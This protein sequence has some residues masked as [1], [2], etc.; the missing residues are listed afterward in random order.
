[1]TSLDH[2][3]VV[4]L[5]D[6]FPPGNVSSIVRAVQIFPSLSLE[7]RAKIDDLAWLLRQ[8][9]ASNRLS[10]TM[11]ELICLADCYSQDR[12]GSYKLTLPADADRAFWV[13]HFVELSIDSTL[14]IL[15]TFGSLAASDQSMLLAFAQ[16]SDQNAPL[17]DPI[18]IFLALHGA[19]LRVGDDEYR[20]P[21][22]SPYLALH[23]DDGYE[24]A[25]YAVSLL[26]VSIL[27]IHEVAEDIL[28]HLAALVPDS[29]KP[30]QLD[31]ARQRVYWPGVLYRGADDTTRN[32]LIRALQNG[33]DPSRI[34]VALAWIGDKVIESLFA[35]W[36]QATPAW[37]E[38]RRVRME[39]YALTAGWHLTKGAERRDLGHSTSYGL[40]SPGDAYRSD[41]AVDVVIPREDYCRWCDRRLVTLL[42]LNLSDSRLAFLGLGSGRL[43]I[44]MC[45][46]CSLY[47]VVF[48]EVDL[49]GES[50]WS[51]LNVQPDIIDFDYEPPPLPSHALVL[52]PHNPTPVVAELLD[53][54]QIGGYPGWVQNADY[55][56][57]PKCQLPMPFVGQV[58]VADI[59]R[60][61]EGI[62]YAFLCPGCLVAATNYQQT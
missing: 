20:H 5:L 11:L 6:L 51:E 22:V 26:S 33:D 10:S 47:S 29:L 4:H 23:P 45:E 12:D 31:L 35:V 25:R 30:V 17:A 28:R 14:E 48:T 8:R 21:H 24:L 53:L 34:L 59:I 46:R 36:S 19:R 43:R 38:N 32:T 42:D 40:V 62:I 56:S 41:A 50:R 15:T 54:S 3:K 52:G 39:V 49:S 61:A 9:K 60:P 18:A 27:R 44:P 2:L 58:S 37:A 55:P 1:L 13:V 57:C 16:A 7:Q